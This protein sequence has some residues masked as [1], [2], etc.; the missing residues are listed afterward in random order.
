[1]ATLGLI[2]IWSGYTFGIFGYSKI[3]S[4]YGTS[5]ALS[6]SDLALPSHRLTYIAAWS[7]A[8]SSS[9]AAGARGNTGSG[10]TA[11][12]QFPL[13]Q[14]PPYPGSTIPSP[15]ATPSGPYVPAG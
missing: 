14:G 1:M 13:P 5:P 3:K 12:G 8:S 10:T 11:P 4:A 2:L 15:Q 6:L 9:S 7:P